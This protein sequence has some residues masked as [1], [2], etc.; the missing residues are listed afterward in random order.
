DIVECVG[1]IKIDRLAQPVSISIAFPEYIGQAWEFRIQ[2]DWLN[3]LS[4]LFC[5]QRIRNGLDC[6]EIMGGDLVR[7]AG[8]ERAGHDGEGAGNQDRPAWP[9]WIRIAQLVEAVLMIVGGQ[10]HDMPDAIVGD[11]L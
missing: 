8:S 7:A 6:R 11:E 5:H 10:K 4:K 9:F 2:A 1:G 3:T